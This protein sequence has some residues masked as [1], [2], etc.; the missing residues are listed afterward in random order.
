[1]LI[2]D[3]VVSEDREIVKLAESFVIHLAPIRLGIV[4]DSSK[5]D[6][7]TD[8]TYRAIAC[9][10]N[11]V[12]QSKSPRDALSYLTDVYAAT[13]SERNIDLSTITAQLKKV[14]SG[15]SAT[16]IDDILGEDSDYDYGRQV[17]AEFIERLGFKKSP[18]ALL[19]GVPLQQSALN[20]DE[21]EET[22]LTEIMQQT[23]N[24]Q[25]A[26]Y[27]GELSDSDNVNDY[28]MSLPHVMPR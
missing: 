3:P 17:A 8:S 2:V 4:F 16:D 19:N 18:Q 9:A 27:K 20:S 25:K 12:S 15:L 28:L 13:K 6:I 11:Y 23:P 24:I 1:M 26:V 22:L 14:T 10:F 7:K 5:S 21:F